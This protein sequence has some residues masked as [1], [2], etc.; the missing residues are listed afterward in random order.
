[1]PVVTTFYIRAR[2]E[3][4]VT[5]HSWTSS[6]DGDV[7]SVDLDDCGDGFLRVT[8]TP[9]QWEHVFS[10]VFRHLDVPQTEPVEVT[11]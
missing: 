1:M 5:A 7:V 8:L 2:H 3:L 4:D 11:S 6:V 10:E 9:D